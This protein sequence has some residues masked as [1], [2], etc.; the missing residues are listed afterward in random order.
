M[1]KPM[2]EIREKKEALEGNLIPSQMGQKSPAVLLCMGLK[3][4]PWRMS[5]HT[6]ISDVTASVLP[7]NTC[8]DIT[9]LGVARN[10]TCSKV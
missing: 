3:R 10:T 4:I 8:L 2:L 9:G 6:P 7:L 5:G 1:Y